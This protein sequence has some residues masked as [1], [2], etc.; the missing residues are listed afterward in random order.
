MVL[1]QEKIRF[2]QTKEL[3]G[4]MD[5]IISLYEICELFRKRINVME[6]KNCMEG[7]SEKMTIKYY[8]AWEQV[9]YYKDE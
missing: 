9:N 2:C 6:H 3:K 4:M 8:I 5:Q 7:S 1:E